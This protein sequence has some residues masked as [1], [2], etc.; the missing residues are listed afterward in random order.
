[1]KQTK[2]YLL[3]FLFI[4]VLSLSACSKNDTPEEKKPENNNQEEVQLNEE[5]LNFSGSVTDLLASKKSLKCVALIEEEGA[6][7]DMTY[8]FDN[9]GEKFRVNTKTIDNV[10]NKEYNSSAILKDGWY[11]F[12]DDTSNIDGMK[13]KAEEDNEEYEDEYVDEFLDDEDDYGVDMDEEFDFDC[14]AWKVD[15][16]VFELPSD[17]SFKDLSELNNFNFIDSMD[18]D[19][20]YLNSEEFDLCSLCEMMPDGPDKDDC[21]SDC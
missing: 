3:M 5:D 15:N 7:V 9:K 13:T 6:T 19:S 16:S 2:I 10:S 11:Y 1:M 8:Y 20:S 18:Q 14:Q 17:K 4:S 12:W 21:L